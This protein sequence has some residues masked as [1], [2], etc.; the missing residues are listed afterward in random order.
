M[1]NIYREAGVTGSRMNNYLTNDGLRASMKS[2]LIDTGHTDSSIILCV[3]QSNTT[4]LAR[5]HNL[6]GKEG[7]RQQKSLF[8]SIEETNIS[9]NA[10][11]KVKISEDV[12]DVPILS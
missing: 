3:C 8:Q 2:L 6:R 5:Y 7:L 10:S 1:K 12:K 11:E 4:T 9:D